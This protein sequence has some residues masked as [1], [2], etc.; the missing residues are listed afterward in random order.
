MHLFSVVCR[1]EGVSVTV[2]G[3][4]QLVLPGALRAVIALLLN[5]QNNRR[6]RVNSLFPVNNSV[7]SQIPV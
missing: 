1:C 7:Y 6:S 5:E 2:V 4:F 3:N